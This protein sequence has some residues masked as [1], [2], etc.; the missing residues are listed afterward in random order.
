MTRRMVGSGDNPYEVVHPFGQV[1]KGT[2]FG[3][4]SH[5]AVDSL[6]R[7]YV[8]Q[9]MDPP[10]LVFDGDGNLLTAWGSGLLVDAHGIYISPDDNVFLVDRDAHEVLKFDLEGRLLLRLGN[11]EKP[12]LQAPFNHPAD[13]AVSPSG[14]IY[15]AD[16]YGN[17]S[18]HKFSSEGQHLL[19]WGSRGTGPSQFTTPHGIWVDRHDRVYVADRENNRVQIFDTEGCFISEWHD[20]YHPMDIFMDA[21]D[22][23]YVTDQIP[24]LTI[25]DRQGN[26]I[27]RWRTPEKGHGLWGDPSGNL[28]CTDTTTGVTKLVKQPRAAQE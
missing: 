2:R 7:V 12:S 5:V 4:T 13:V 16:G 22:K 23:I 18:V 19:S 9:R 1:P 21:E 24:R 11:R 3:N 15:V 10:V 17:S 25:L 6:A 8:Y 20:F 27:D 28:Y 26:L 14:E